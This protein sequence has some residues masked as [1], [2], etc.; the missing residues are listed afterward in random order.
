MSIQLEQVNKSYHGQPVV[1]DF[2]LYIETGELFVLLGASG[3][4]KST[5]LR[6]IAGLTEV[7]SGRIL[8]NETDVT[9]LPPQQRGTGFVFQNY[10]LF[11]HMTV[12]QNIEFGLSIRRVRRQ[13]RA[14]RVNELLDLIELSG[15]GDRLPTQLSGGQQQRV[16]LARALAYQPNVLLLD[17]PFGALDVKIRAQLRQNLRDIQKRLGLTAILVTHD[18]EEAFDIADRIGIVEQGQLLEV[19]APSELYRRP[20]NLFTATFLGSTNILRAHRNGKTVYVGDAG[21]PAPPETE[22]L[23]GQP[24]EVLCRPEE[25]ELSLTHPVSYDSVIGSGM[26]EAIAFAGPVLRVSVRLA[27]KNQQVIQA[28]LSPAEVREREI[29]PGQEVWVSLRDFHLLPT[30]EAQETAVAITEGS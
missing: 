4:G 5:L 22:H 3:S 23:R 16:A 8:L 21:I 14:Q 20:Q 30:D 25:V 18:Q 29:E 7:D 13:V 19:G 27:G 28:L 2:T 24:V 10:S 12:A 15:Y 1:R 11:R 17:E 6:M 26:V 9:Q